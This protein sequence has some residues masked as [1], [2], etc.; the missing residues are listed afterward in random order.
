MEQ[1]Q[2]KN[3]YSAGNYQEIIALWQNLE[4]RKQFTEWDYVY[5]MNTFYAQKNYEQCLEVYRAFHAVFPESDKLDDKMSW[6]CYHARIKGF[7][8]KTG[9][10][11]KLRRQAEYII[12]HS[13]QSVYSPKWFMVKYMLEHMK[14]GDFGTNMDPNLA[15]RY[16]E[17]VDPT[18]LSTKS[19]EYTAENGRRI[20]L[21]SD[22]ENWYKEH[23]KVLLAVGQYE[24]CIA[25]CDAALFNLHT[26]HS[27][28]DS[29][30]RFRKAKALYALGKTDESR[31]YI[32]E[33]QTRGLDHWC[34]YQL[35]YEMDKSENNIENA[36]I[37]AC[38]CATADPSHEMRVKFYDDFSQFLEGNGYEREA[39]LHRQLVLLIRKENEWTLRE[40]HLAWKLPDEIAK[41]NKHAVLKEL[42]EFWNK[43]KNRNKEYFTGVIK[44]LLSEGK[45][46]FIEANDGNSYYFN[47]RDFQKR[48]TVPQ[49]GMKV[50]FALTDRLDKSKGVVKKNAIELTVI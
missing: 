31:K 22:K 10:A 18:S 27:N 5:V 3:L 4:E 11:E 34:F 49:E 28:N 50:R 6:S 30:F 24:K 37:H 39:M 13:G 41:M 16:I 38:M 7:D 33:I 44:R 48:G 26:F 17:Q 43:W 2:M 46:G 9:D 14:S 23:T 42:Q 21:A 25:S 32:K 19:E 47:A 45:S 20:S 12:T 35:L 40:N 8:F 15:L 36:M 29:W 1:Y